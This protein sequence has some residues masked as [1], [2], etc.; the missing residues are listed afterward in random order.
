MTTTTTAETS[1]VEATGASA[2]LDAAV[3]ELLQCDSTLD[4]VAAVLRLLG[5]L[6]LDAIAGPVVDADIT[7]RQ[8]I[9]LGRVQALC[10]M[11]A[12]QLTERWDPETRCA[13]PSALREVVREVAVPC[14]AAHLGCLENVLP[15]QGDGAFCT[16]DCLVAH[17]RSQGE[18][19]PA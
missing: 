7:R 8:S 18:T 2:R 15:W 5:K 19:W 1:V 4:D 14:G 10:W 9:A 16:D 6:D 17:M 12:K 11:L 13:P 3:R